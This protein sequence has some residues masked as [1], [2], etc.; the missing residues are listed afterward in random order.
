MTTALIAAAAMVVA[1]IL[2]TIMVMAEAKERGW[3]AGLLD[4][5]GWYVGIATTTISVSSLE[6]HNTMQKVYVLVFV[7]L[8]NVVGTKLGQVTG[9]KLLKSKTL[10]QVAAAAR[11]GQ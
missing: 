11:S 8:A 1:D 10:R 2:A 9:S 7:G 6:G 3:L 4:M 5:A